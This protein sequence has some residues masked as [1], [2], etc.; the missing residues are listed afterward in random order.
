MTQHPEVEAKVVAE[1]DALELL[2]TPG[3]PNPRPVTYTD[4]G[5]LEYLQ[6]CVK[7][8]ASMQDF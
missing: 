3:R 5:K 4:L 2:V 1:L 7:V 6:A 8:R